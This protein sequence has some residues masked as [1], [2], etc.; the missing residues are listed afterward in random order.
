MKARTAFVAAALLAAAAWPAGAE[1]QAAANQEAPAYRVIEADADL[2]FSQYAIRGYH[3]GEDR[4]LIIDAGAHGWYRA[5]LYEPCASDLRWGNSIGID[6]RPNGHLDKWGRAI[7]RGYRCP[8]RT[9]DRIERPSR[10]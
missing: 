10:G 6:A 8:F 4:S 7:V 3:V 9:F 1:T 2:P 5:T